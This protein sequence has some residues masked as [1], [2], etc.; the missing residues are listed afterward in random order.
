MVTSVIFENAGAKA[1]VNLIVGK[2]NSGISIKRILHFYNSDEFETSFENN[3]IDIY[4]EDPVRLCCG[5]SFTN[6]L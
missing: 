3:S 4:F 2:S 5:T 1:C 6:S